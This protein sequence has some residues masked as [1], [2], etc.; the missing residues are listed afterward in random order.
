VPTGRG[1][2]LQRIEHFC[3]SFRQ[4]DPLKNS[5]RATYKLKW[6]ET[7]GVSTR[8]SFTPS[9]ARRQAFITILKS[10]IAAVD[11]FRNF[12]VVPNNTE[13]EIVRVTAM[14]R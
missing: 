13:S 10:P 2:S 11:S 14:A 4:I 1:F 8:N 7:F 3:L 9:F 6:L 12:S 5:D